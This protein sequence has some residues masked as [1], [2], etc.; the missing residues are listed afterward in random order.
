[1]LPERPAATLIKHCLIDHACH[2]A[3]EAQEQAAS[4]HRCPLVFMQSDD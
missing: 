4:L 2:Q 1:M 3:C